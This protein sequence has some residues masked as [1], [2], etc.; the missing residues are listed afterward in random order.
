MA[1]LIWLFLAF[2]GQS[3]FL[4]RLSR[5]KDGFGSLALAKF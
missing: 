1:K 3:G 5:F 2:F 4:Y